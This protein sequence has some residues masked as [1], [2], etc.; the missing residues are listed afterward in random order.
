M[1][2]EKKEP[3]TSEPQ[4]GRHEAPKAVARRPVN[5]DAVAA[6]IA[7]LIGLVAILVAGYEVESVRQQTQAEVWP[8]IN[9]GESDKLPTD[10]IENG[11]FTSHGGVVLAINSGVGPAI[12]RRAEV[13]VDNKPQP[14]WKQVFK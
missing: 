11:R 5:W 3:D 13:L 12:V 7:A 8:H 2:G 10:V 4:T 6:I 1:T 14:N 9:L